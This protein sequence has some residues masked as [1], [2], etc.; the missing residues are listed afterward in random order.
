[1]MHIFDFN[2]FIETHPNNFVMEDV[3]YKTIDILNLA[4]S[5]QKKKEKKDDR[6]R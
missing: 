1:M 2:F 4:Q 5:Y 3:K 6:K